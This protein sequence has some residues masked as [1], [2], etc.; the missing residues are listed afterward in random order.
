MFELKYCLSL[1]TAML[2]S[3]ASQP[4]KPKVCG[5]DGG[6]G[7]SSALLVCVSYEEE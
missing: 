5:T 2:L 1:S 4:Q 6:K 7:S 3:V